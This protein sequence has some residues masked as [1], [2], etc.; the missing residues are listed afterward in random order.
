MVHL[1]QELQFKERG[2]QTLKTYVHCAV[3][4]TA[5]P[6]GLGPS[7]PLNVGLGSLDSSSVPS[8]FTE[9]TV[10]QGSGL[11]RAMGGHFR[12]WSSHRPLNSWSRKACSSR[13]S[14][15]SQSQKHLLLGISVSP[16]RSPQEA[17]EN[18]RAHKQHK[19]FT[20]CGP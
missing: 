2:F 16:S 15:A 5:L 6:S 14:F 1:Q 8:A 18:S 7:P 20:S 17:Q 11:E 13:L 4:P 9:N 3:P 19:L 12:T 10:T